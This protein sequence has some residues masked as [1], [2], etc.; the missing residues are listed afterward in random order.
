MSRSTVNS[1]TLSRSIRPRLIATCPALRAPIAIA[2]TATAPRAKP[3]VA[4]PSA[5]TPAREEMVFDFRKVFVNL[6]FFSP[7]IYQIFHRRLRPAGLERH[8]AGEYTAEWYDTRSPCVLRKETFHA[9]GNWRPL[10][11]PPN[12]ENMALLRRR[13]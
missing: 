13:L 7:G 6:L 2:P 9:G 10:A 5:A 8:P 4:T 12:A 1:P 3:T 11:S